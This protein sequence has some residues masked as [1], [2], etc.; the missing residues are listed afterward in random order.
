MDNGMQTSGLKYPGHR[1]RIWID[2][3]HCG[4]LVAGAEGTSCWHV[5][6]C[7]CSY[8]NV[9][10]QGIVIISCI[11]LY[12]TI[13]CA[14]ILSWFCAYLKVILLPAV[15]HVMYGLLQQA[16]INYPC[17][18]LWP[19]W[20]VSYLCLM[21]H[22]SERSVLYLYTGNTIPC[23]GHSAVTVKDFSLSFAFFFTVV[24]SLHTN[25]SEHSASS[26]FIAGRYDVWLGLRMWVIV[27]EKVRKIA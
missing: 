16:L 20:Y 10:I 5:M 11:I 17:S 7:L 21:G 4:G 22:H 24:C 19:N 9:E 14:L 18:A 6:F 15:G 8:W 25:V 27:C 23:L 12:P 3:L 2:Q 13:L 1:D 26:I